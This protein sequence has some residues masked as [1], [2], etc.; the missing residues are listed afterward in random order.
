MCTIAQQWGWYVCSTVISTALHQSLPQFFSGHSCLLYR[1]DYL[2][3][4]FPV[5]EL[6]HVSGLQHMI[7]ILSEPTL[8]RCSYSK[9]FKGFE[10][11]P[12]WVFSYSP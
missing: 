9:S 4:S 10:M 5:E 6:C 12:L 7:C 11:K 8:Q 3:V 2:K 1:L